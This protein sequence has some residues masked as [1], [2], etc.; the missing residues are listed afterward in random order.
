MTRLPSKL[1]RS[2]GTTGNVSD[3]RDRILEIVGDAVDQVGAALEEA[4]KPTMDD[5]RDAAERVRT[6][7]VVEAAGAAIAA[8]LPLAARV[9]R[10]QV[11]RRNARHAA[12]ALPFIM[13]RHPVVMGASLVGGALLGLELLHRRRAPSDSA[14]TR[15]LARRADAQ[16]GIATG[17]DLDEEVA[18]MEGEG[19]EPSAAP[20]APGSTPRGVARIGAGNGSGARRR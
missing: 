2:G 13:R 6:S 20:G 9:A 7:H 1:R 18:R 10:R 8:A 15:R 4:P 3:L 5:A 14:R 17:F 12:T 16:A 11:N 19:G